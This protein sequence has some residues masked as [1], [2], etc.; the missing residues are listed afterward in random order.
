V[1]DRNSLSAVYLGDGWIIAAAH[2]FVGTTTFLGVDYEPVPGTVTVLDNGDGTTADLIVWGI[3]PH[4]PLPSLTVRSLT[5]LPAGEV[6]MIGN[7]RDRGA[8][9]N[10]NNTG[11]YVTP[12]TVN[13]A[14]DGFFWAGSKSMRWGSNKITAALASDP[15]DTVSFYS[16][17]D[18]NGPGRT[19][20]EAHAAEGDSGG[21]VFSKETG[22]WELAGLMFLVTTLLGDP[23]VP[24]SG[25]QANT[26]FHTNLT[27]IIDLSFYHD[28]I[29]DLTAIP[30]P[31][32]AGGTML[33][34]GITFLAIFGRRRAS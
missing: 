4:P 30:V 1:G 34:A 13:P 20:H 5:S 3:Y 8:A 27:G 15:F 33:A 10:T 11:A 29:V 28:D 31:E 2:V 7:G 6:V 22:S 16:T 26:A 23:E 19:T 12:P 24:G 32:P 25:Q 17:F 21:A 18:K 14:L 9:T